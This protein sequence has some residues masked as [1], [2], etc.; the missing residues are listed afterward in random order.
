M[1]HMIPVSL[2][3]VIAILGAILLLLSCKKELKEIGKKYGK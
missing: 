2:V 1:E 3:G